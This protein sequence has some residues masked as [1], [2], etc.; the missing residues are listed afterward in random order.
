LGKGSEFTL[1][2]PLEIAKDAIVYSAISEHNQTETPEFPTLRGCVL[3]VEDY[4]PN[5]LVATCML[6]SLG[7]SYN[8]AETGKEALEMI[9]GA[10]GKYTAVLMDVQ[11]PDM[12][13]FEAT[14][15][16]R[17]E[18]KAKGLPHLPIIAVTAHA[19]QGDRARCLKAGMDDYISK[20]FQPQGL[21]A[22]FD[23][24]DAMQ[25]IHAENKLVCTS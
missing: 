13:G 2:L 10:R 19:M 15:L 16:I 18:E 9:Y 6:E 1:H 25:P 12:D 7:Y 5:V 11:M 22:V 8:I 14:R 23:R 21:R 3:L 17:E 20:P 24:L 4:K